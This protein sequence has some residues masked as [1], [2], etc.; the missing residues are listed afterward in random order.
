MKSVYISRVENMIQNY[1]L[2]KKEFKWDGDL[3]KHFVALTYASKESQLDVLKI[4]ALKDYIKKETGAFSPFRG[5]ML[6]ALCGLICASTSAPE[7]YFDGMLA[8]QKIMK[9]VGFKNSTYLPT[10]LYTLS[11]VYEG[12]DVLG[13]GERAMDVY[14]E[15]KQNHPFLTSGDDYALAILLASTSHSPDLLEQYYSALN[16]EGFTKTNGLQMLSHIMSFNS[17]DVKSSVTKCKRIYDALKENKLKVYADYYPAIGLVS[18][19]EDED[20][21]IITD[22]IEVASYLRNQKKYKWL[23]KGMNILMASALITSEYIKDNEG[24]IVSTAVSV[25]IQAIISAQQ[26]AMIAAM[27][28]STAAASAST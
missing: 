16:S 28:A 22:L 13:F 19:L 10:A 11:T 25:S 20:D 5:Q 15:M 18:L 26:A 7:K 23:G 6:F 8:N 12:T 14:K 21:Q 9:S 1:E 3:S 27:T 2:L 17:G 4:K 24:D